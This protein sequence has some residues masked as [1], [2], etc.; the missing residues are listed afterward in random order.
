MVMRRRLRRWLTPTR[1]LRSVPPLVHAGLLVALAAQLAWGLAAPGP[2]A[3]AQALPA[4]PTEPVLR[5]AALGEPA[6]LAAAGNVWLQF[7]DAQPGVSLGFD[8]LDYAR[9][10]AW[11]E[12]WLALAPQSEYPLLLAVRVYGQVHDPGRQRIMLDF[13]RTQFLKRPA[14]RWRWLAEATLMAHHRLEDLALAARYARALAQRTE[15]G[16][17]PHWARDLQIGVRQARGEYAG[18]R[19]I[20]ERRLATGAIEDAR[21]LQYLARTLEQLKRETR[22]QLPP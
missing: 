15:P 11:L 13:A 19:A 5:L 4:P 10:R 16:E 21:E 9:V 18:A 12:R 17:V 1:A 3:R 2:E 6:T 14:E 7:R 22:R 20:V 8:E